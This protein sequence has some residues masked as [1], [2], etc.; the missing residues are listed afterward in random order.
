[1]IPLMTLKKVMR[2]AKGS[3]MVLKTTADGLLV[4][5]FAEGDAG[6]VRVGGCGRSFYGVGSALDGRGRVDLDE[7][8]K[9]VEGHVGQAA[10]KQHG[11]DA[12]FADGFVERGD[13]VLF[14]D[15]AFLE[16]L[17]HELVFA[18]GYQLDESLVAGFGFRRARR[19]FRLRLC[20]GHRRRG[21]GKGLHGDEIDYAVKS[22]GVGDGQLDGNTV[23]AP[24]LVNVVNEGAQ[25]ASA[26]GLGVVHLVDEH[27]AGNVGFLGESPNALGDGLNA[28]LG[29]DEDDGGFD[30]EQRGAGFVGKHVEAG[31][32]DEIDFYALPL[33]K[34]DGVLH[35]DAAGNFFFV[36]GGNGRAVFD[37]ALGG[38]HF[39]GMQH[40]GDQG[41]FT[42]VRMPHYS[43]VADLTSLVRFH[44]VLLVWFI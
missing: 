16:I 13:E 44:L 4:V 8:E 43:Y 9:V 41:G 15:C 1:M 35:G 14:S 24:A 22:L 11:E 39:G 32:V 6:V 37:A 12:V 42:A 10:G 21:I 5:D 3:V 2:P 20:R 38:S 33:D 18:F 28:I 31:G 26:A 7:V 23:A 36:V 27:D 17:F 34:G 40:G 19:E 29:V 30:G 25:S